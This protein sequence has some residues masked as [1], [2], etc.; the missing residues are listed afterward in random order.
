MGIWDQLGIAQTKDQKAIKAAYRQK[1]KTVHPEEDP[2]GFQRLRTAYEQALEAAK[3]TDA[4]Q[5]N[6]PLGQWKREM[7]TLY[8]DYA[9]RIDPGEWK[10]LCR[11]DFCLNLGTRTA[12]RDALL[13]F[14]MQEYYLPQSVWQTLDEIFDFTN[15]REELMELYP[16]KFLENVVYSGIHDKVYVPYELFE[17][18]H[19]RRPDEYL[20][21]FFPAR[22]AIR[23]WEDPEDAQ[24][25]LQALLDVGIEHPYTQMVLA[26]MQVRQGEGEQALQR[27]EQVCQDYP[28]EIPLLLALASTAREVGQPERALQAAQQALVLD[29]EDVNGLYQKAMALGELQRWNE[30]VEVYGELTKRYPTDQRLLHLEGQAYEQWANQ[31]EETLQQEPENRRARLDLADCCLPLHTPQRGLELLEHFV[32]TAQERYDYENIL[33]NLYMQLERPQECL[34]HARNWEQAIR[35]LPEEGDDPKLAWKKTRIPSAY[36][37]QAVALRQLGQKEE[38]VACLERAKETAPDDPRIYRML[39]SW[40]WQDADW[41]QMRQSAQKL[42]ELL[43]DAVGYYYMGVALFEDMR[44]GE[45]FQYFNE[46]LDRDGSNLGCYLY[47]CRV[48]LIYD[49]YDQAKELLQF[50][51]DNGVKCD[52]VDFLK[53][54]LIHLTAEDERTWRSVFP[55]YRELLKK[56]EQGESDIDFLEDVYFAASFDPD[57]DFD[58]KTKLVHKGMQLRRT[59]DLYCR[60]AD[61]LMGDYRVHEARDLAL[62]GLQAY[63]FS[64]VLRDRLS[65]ALEA[66]RH[67]EEAAKYRDEIAQST[68][69]GRAW[70]QAAQTHLDARQYDQCKACLDRA[71]ELTGEGDAELCHL[72]ALW[73]RDHGTQQEALRWA[74]GAIE[75]SSEED[76]ESHW[77]FLADLRSFYG[78]LDQETADA[79]LQVAHRTEDP[80]DYEAS[81]EVWVKARV[82]DRAGQGMEDYCRRHPGQQAQDLYHLYRARVMLRKGD[83]D[84]CWSCLSKVAGKYNA[85]RYFVLRAQ[86]ALARGK[87]RTAYQ[88]FRRIPRDQEGLRQ[89]PV[90]LFLLWE[91]G[92]REELHQL[93]QERLDRVRYWGWAGEEPLALTAQAMAALFLGDVERAESNIAQAGN[94]PLCRQCTYSHCRDARMAQ[95]YV[96][97]YRGDLRT[98]LAIYQ[99]EYQRMP[100]D[101]DIILGILR[102]KRKM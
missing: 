58:G 101:E 79:Y 74:N 16:P 81:D 49:K 8:W 68:G 32:P 44:Y 26:Q 93:A 34:E 55:I 24:K 12:A 86:Y 97:E 63:P 76:L 72:L 37:M 11:E 13:Q 78:L 22:D 89:S 10:K 71:L 27:M 92:R 61:L 5:D 29:E 88:W 56:A 15:T 64:M 46:A 83:L 69:E 85:P 84:A 31:L 90:F 70:R 28:R 21:R 50:L 65:D 17:E 19:D 40:S 35:D 30:A 7:E 59:L 20:N 41:E 80:K 77:N 66:M 42:M 60:L 2:E 95:A 52:A 75:A 23:A 54:R 96:A 48:L 57:L 39:C 38:A 1:L 9:R 51:E 3:E 94:W 25:K 91:L 53:T 36:Q 100:D 87:R 67:Y 45:S 98:A 99:E 43:S 4:P 47:K 6:T 62:K 82:W 14:L 33:G 102:V 18:C 73:N